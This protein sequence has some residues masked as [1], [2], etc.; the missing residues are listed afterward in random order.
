MKYEN[1]IYGL[2]ALIIVIA[3][4]MNIMHIPYGNTLFVI[5][6]LAM[7]VYQNRHLRKLKK[8]V[9]ELEKENRRDE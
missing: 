5:G 9:N 8:R 2:T 6:V 3:A 7:L 1:L 4:V